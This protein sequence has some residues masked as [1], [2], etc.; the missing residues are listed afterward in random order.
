ME[1]AVTPWEMA[2]SLGLSASRT[3][4][5][6]CS[7]LQQLRHRLYGAMEWL[8]EALKIRQKCSY[9]C[10]SETRPRCISLWK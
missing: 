5:G 6:K 7:K 10:S 2:N 8:V 1:Q 9:F 3:K 4:N